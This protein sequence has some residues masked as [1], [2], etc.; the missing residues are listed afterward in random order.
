MS[1]LPLSPRYNTRYDGCAGGA[2][3]CIRCFTDAFRSSPSLARRASRKPSEDWRI[4][5]LNGWS[6]TVDPAKLELYLGAQ[7]VPFDARGEQAEGWGWAD[8]AAGD[9]ALYGQACS[10]F[11]R[12]GGALATLDVGCAE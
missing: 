3:S 11:K 1:V 10:E 7:R 5:A 2:A 9:V 12:A 6:S 4:G 8:A